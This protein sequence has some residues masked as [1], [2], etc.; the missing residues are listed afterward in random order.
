MVREEITVRNPAVDMFL[1]PIPKKLP[2]NL[3]IPEQE[4]RLEALSQDPRSWSVVQTLQ[5]GK[6]VRVGRVAG[7]GRTPARRPRRRSRP[8]RERLRVPELCGESEGVPRET[9]LKR[10]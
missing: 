7:G 1:L 5:N 4:Q 3:S 6:R 2:G 9:R 8:I 10:R